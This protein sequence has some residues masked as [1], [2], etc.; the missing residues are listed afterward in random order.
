MN[1]TEEIKNRLPIEQVV[2][3]YVPLKKAG[4]IYKA[5]CPFHNEKTPS[6]T[7]SPDRGI[8]KCFGCDEGGDIFDFVMKIEGLSFPEALELLAEKAG[9]TL[10][11]KH[12][13]TPTSG[14]NSQPQTK[15]SRLFQ[16]NKFAALLWHTI[17][18]KHPKAQDAL[19]YL[20]N[21][22]GLNKESIQAF[23]VGYSPYGNTTENELIKHGFNK[24][25]ISLA[26]NPNKMQD[27]IT[28]PISDIT[29]QVVGFTGRLLELKDDPKTHAS[30]GPKYWNT[31]E[32]PVFI[33]SRAVYALHLAKNSIQ[34]NDLILMAEG[35]MDVITLHQHGYNNAVASS[36]TALTEQQLLL[37]RRFSDNIALAYDQ[38]KAGIA[39]TKR[40]IELALSL[41]MNPFVVVVPNGKDPAECLQ[42]QPEAWKK[43]YENRMPF[44]KWLIDQILLE[45]SP[46]SSQLDPFK[47]KEAAKQIL[48]WLA[49]ILNPIEL[50]DWI[51][52]IA[53]KL[54]TGEENIRAALDKISQTEKNYSKTANFYKEE[55]RSQAPQSS[56][57]T[58]TRPVPTF[59]KLESAFAISLFFP[60][61]IPIVEKDSTI[62]EA[63]ITPFIKRT[64]ELWP[65]AKE[66][67]AKF[68][69]HLKEKVDKKFLLEAEE[70]VTAYNQIELDAGQ[71][72]E[73]FLIIVQNA[74]SNLRDEEKNRISKKIAEAQAMGN[75][76]EVKA[77]FKELQNLL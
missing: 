26:G 77:L 18:T 20:I 12:P 35:Q 63:L 3:S 42:K 61:I 36:G 29:G 72:L 41:E 64:F 22:R 52:F 28:F 31:P 73:E 51:H 58:N 43:A 68:N 57:Q 27:R 8:Y 67:P 16:L 60:Q 5:C 17:L 32:T 2:G 4:R 65:I 70:R 6:F 33:K 62:P 15:K 50:A 24:N 14:D 48:P 54:Q 34:D 25:E 44:M 47:K 37:L 19:N 53:A 1:E 59:N 49:K 55:D 11:K 71:A 7:V 74:K 46:D 13:S 39:T 30:R 75:I 9:V 21:E 40:A 56:S 45:I 69:Q 10:E 38:D 66:N 23:N 76:E